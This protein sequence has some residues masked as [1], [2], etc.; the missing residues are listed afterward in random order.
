MRFLATPEIARRHRAF[1]GG[2]LLADAEFSSEPLHLT[3]VGAKGDAV[4]RELF[5]A[6]LR[7][8]SGYKQLEWWDRRENPDAPP[9]GGIVFPELPEAAAFICADQRCSAPISR[10]AELREKLARRADNPGARAR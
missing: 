2:L 4:A 6:G 8:P 5:L 7:H 1:V 10:P 3:V 9:P